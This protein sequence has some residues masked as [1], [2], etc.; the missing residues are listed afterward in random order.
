MTVSGG[1]ADG[2]LAALAGIADKAAGRRYLSVRPRVCFEAGYDGFWLPRFLT[3]RGID[4]TVLD[5]SSFLVP[6]RGRR[7]KTDRIDVEVMVFTLKAFLLGD[8]SVC[9]AMRVP[10]PE[11]ED[12]KRVSRE[13]VQLVKQRTRNVNRIRGLLNLHGIRRVQGLHGGDWRAWLDRVRTGDGRPLG[14][15]LLGELGRQFE[16]LH[17]VI[18]QL[19]APGTERAAIAEQPGM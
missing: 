3:D 17:L 14:S 10:S 4:V 11:E 12:A 19:R 2:L 1:D 7:V 5:A 16:R 15:H 18:A 8:K 6:R 13:R 9:R